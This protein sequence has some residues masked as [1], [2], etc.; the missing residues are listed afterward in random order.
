MGI[1]KTMNALVSVAARTRWPAALIS[2]LLL[3]WGSSS[4]GATLADFGFEHLRTVQSLQSQRRLLVIL[5]QFPDGQLKT[6]QSWFDSWVFGPGPDGRSINGYFRENSNNR[7]SWSRGGTIQITVPAAD[8]FTNIYSRVKEDGALADLLYTSNIVQR[9]MASSLFDFAACDADT[10]QVITPSEL[11]ILVIGNDGGGATRYTGEVRPPGSACAWN[12]VVALQDHHGE[13]LTA[14]H[15]L[16]HQLGTLDLYGDECHNASRTLMDCTI[17][18]VPDDPRTY[19]L[20][21]WHKLQFGWSTP[22][23]R[24]LAG[25]GVENIPAAQAMDASAPLLLYHPARGTQEF[26][27]LE[28][29]TPSTPA[30]GGYDANTTDAGLVIWHVLQN[31]KKEP[32]WLAD[33]AL[34]AHA[35]SQWW[36]CDRCKGLHFM[37]HQDSPGACPAGGHHNT[38]SPG[39]SDYRLR[40]NDAQAPGQKG[41]KWCRNCQGLFFGVNQ[42]SSRCPAGVAHEGSQSGDYTLNNGPRAAYEDDNWRWCHKCQ[43]LFFG[44]ATKTPSKCPAGNAHEGAGSGTYALP[45]RMI[46]YALAVEGAP[47]LIYAGI[48]PWVGENSTPLLRWWDG[49]SAGARFFVRPFGAGAGSLTVEWGQQDCWVDFNL[50]SGP[51]YGTFAQPFNTL[52]EGIN[53]VFRGGN[54]FIKAGQRKETTTISKPMRIQSYQGAATLGR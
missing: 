41:W 47:D 5:A 50:P 30:G 49:T 22:R 53:G 6:N 34:P 16:A 2:S 4:R 15:E 1:L 32:E 29:R 28:Y 17:T 12:G 3:F 7:F 48:V 33:A 27:L 8:R 40:L 13:F 23:I 52:A 44:G 26:Y 10:N 43:G 37:G 19:H 38:L 36:Y 35:Q 20:D 42:S 51:E 54:L 45:F 31:E 9:A 21:P 11:T 46:H 18:Y 39:V 14:C 24:S 25:G